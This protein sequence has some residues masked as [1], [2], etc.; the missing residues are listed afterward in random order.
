MALGKKIPEINFTGFIIEF[1]KILISS[2]IMGI[3]VYF[4]NST[5]NG[6]GIVGFTSILIDI[7]IAFV[8]YLIMIVITRV[9]SIDLYVGAIKKK[10]KKA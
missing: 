5:L 9:K 2:A 10:L 8:V 4:V 7:V 3:A 6:L 1:V